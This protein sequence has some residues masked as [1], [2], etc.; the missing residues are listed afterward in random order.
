VLLV[1]PRVDVGRPR[2]A[3]SLVVAVDASDLSAAALPVIASW[4]RTF[5]GGPVTAAQV[6]PLV[7]AI[8]EQAGTDLESKHVRRYADRL[9][10][11]GIAARGAVI[12]A[13]EPV[14]GL[15]EAAGGLADPVLVVT[16]ERWP[17]AGTHW[18]STSRKLAFRSPCPVLVVPASEG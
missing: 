4:V 11:L 10:E 8:A 5:G 9:E 2:S 12:H 15:I 6:I 18:R 1:G 14:A 17:D 3:P 13:G 16:A 7:P